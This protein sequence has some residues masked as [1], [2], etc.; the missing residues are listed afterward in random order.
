MPS[1]CTRGVDLGEED[2]G[3]ATHSIS[4]SDTLA[5]I[6]TPPALL[7][8]AADEVRELA[9]VCLRAASNADLY[10]RNLHQQPTASPTI[11]Q[12]LY[13]GVEDKGRAFSAWT[14]FPLGLLLI[15]LQI[16]SRSGS[17][18]CLYSELVS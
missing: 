7:E 14:Q 1:R 2:D 11:S 18:A 8:A 10:T 12:I 6:A 4:S 17:E 5:V 16:T 13:T 9:M 3:K 15:L